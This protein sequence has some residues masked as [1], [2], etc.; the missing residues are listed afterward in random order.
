MAMQKI[1]N[2]GFFVKEKTE[3][4]LCLSS[5]IYLHNFL[6][7]CTFFFFFHFIILEVDG[8]EYGNNWP[9]FSFS[10]CQ[11]FLKTVKKNNLN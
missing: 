11:L 8:W 7:I 10:Y 1:K 4:H 9:S 2:W 3:L 5:N 6:T